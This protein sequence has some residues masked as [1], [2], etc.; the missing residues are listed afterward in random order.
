MPRDHWLKDLKQ[1]RYLLLLL[2][3]VLTFTLGVTE[4]EHAYL[5]ESVATIMMAMVFVIVF[6]RRIFRLLSLAAGLGALFA[7]WNLRLVSE[8]S[9]RVLEIVTHLGATLFFALS[10][11]MVLRHLFDRRA[12]RFDDILGTMCGYLLAALAWANLYAAIELMSPGA[13]LLTGA[14]Q[15]DLTHWH[16]RESLFMYFSLTTLTTIG[17]G[18][19]T[20]VVAPARSAAMFE[21]VFGQFYLAI[22]VAQLVGSKLAEA[23]A[24][25]TGERR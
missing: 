17:Y 24:R 20:P 3:L 25:N 9:Q 2:A 8:P 21:G 10:V 1:H 15:P 4:A 13:F 16:E 18:D 14:D 11:S 22:V 12:V 7:L 19:V 23:G 6:D 5:R